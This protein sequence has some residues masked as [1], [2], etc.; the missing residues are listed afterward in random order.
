MLTPRQKLIL[1]AVIE[2]YV[3]SA[4]PV[5]SRT[6]SKHEEI[7]FSAATIRNEMS[8]LEEMGFLDQPHTSA[9][10][11]PS[12]KGYRFFVDH[13][14]QTASED[15][16]PDTKSLHVLRDLFQSRIV[17]VER[18]IQQ[19]SQVLSH[20]T[21]Q[22]AIVLGPQV[23]SEKVQRID[24][25][26]LGYG[27]AVAILVTDSGHVEDRQV[28]LAEDLPLDELAAIIRTLNEKLV[29]VPLAKLK[30]QMY[31]EIGEQLADTVGRYEDALQWLDELLNTRSGEER[32][33]I[34]GA[35]NI[36]NQPEFQDIEK[37]KPL[38]S[39]LETSATAGL[40]LAGEGAGVQVK[41]G[42]ENSVVPL[43][44]CTV[45]SA[46][47]AVGGSIVG[48]IGI[49]GPTRMDYARIIQI[50]DYTSKTLTKILTDGNHNHS[51]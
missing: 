2:D 44:D 50:L 33:Y 24:L 4:E 17:E 23:F 28:K 14:L 5:G 7:Q 39:L 42:L 36:L 15:L 25:I 49:L 51:G 31:H 10:R 18:A 13:L 29:G 41:I 46:T 3:Q 40:V 34:G 27:R 47:Y 21:H 9:G 6:L 45:I 1:N 12:Q 32:V 20:L 30:S 43:Q 48:R 38:L 8:D 19:T 37:V 11:I 26:P 22:T 35:S 16:E